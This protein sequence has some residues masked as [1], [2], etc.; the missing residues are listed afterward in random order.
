M[1][2]EM[3][4]VLAAQVW[5]YWFAPPL[6]ATTLLF[7]LATAVGYYRKVAV[8]RFVAEQHRRLQASRSLEREQPVRRLKQSPAGDSMPLAA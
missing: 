8:P 3:S 5:T 6:M 4:V 2:L 7:L 1:A